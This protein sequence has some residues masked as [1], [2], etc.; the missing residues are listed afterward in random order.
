MAIRKPAQP[1]INWN[2]PLAKNLVQDFEFWEGSGVTPRELVLNRA[3]AFSNSPAFGRS[4]YGPAMT[5]PSSYTGIITY[6]DS[7]FYN[8]GKV[9]SVEFLIYL[10]SFTSSTFQNIAQII[11]DNN[12]TNLTATWGL[13]QF[14]TPASQGLLNLDFFNGGDQTAVS[15]SQLS[16]STWTHCVITTDGVNAN[17]YIQGK[18]D[19]AVAYTVTPGTQQTNSWFVGGQGNGARAIDGR[20]AYVRRWNNRALNANDVWSL[21]NNP[22]Q[23]F[24][25]P[26]FLPYYMSPAA[27]AVV[28]RYYRSLMGVGL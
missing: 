7:A 22:F 11:G 2:H 16:L 18:L 21:Y 5:F 20:L 8:S 12:N 9:T 10:N 3:G 15:T 4:P 17:F 26:N 24:R 23:M 6:A 19:R 13:G 14:N 25:K 1:I 27:A 28:A